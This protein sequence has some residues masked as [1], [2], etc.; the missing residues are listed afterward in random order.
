MFIIEEGTV[1]CFKTI[2][3]APKLVKT[4]ATGDAFG[5]LA[6]LYN[7]PR[8]ASVE[9]RDHCVLWQLDRQ[10]FNHIVKDAAAAKRQRYEGFLKSVPLFQSMEP[11]EIQQLV[12]ALKPES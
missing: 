3:G 8:A 12:D 4:C 1:E 10:T 6:L 5:E 9:S 2:D 11:Y 7:C